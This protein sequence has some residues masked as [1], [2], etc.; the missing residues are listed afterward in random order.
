M[1]NRTGACIRHGIANSGH[2]KVFFPESQVKIWLY[3][4]STDM[5]KSFNG[6]V[7]LVKNELKEKPLS[8]DLFVFINRKQTHL[9][10]LYFDRSGYCIWMKRL[11][12]GRFQYPSGSSDKAALDLTRLKLIIEG[13]DL[14]SILQRKRYSH[15]I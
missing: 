4:K 8:G 13:I 5:R 15:K 10:I 3:T 6:L 1:G 12:E 7:S 2:L 11:E 14:Q 9:K